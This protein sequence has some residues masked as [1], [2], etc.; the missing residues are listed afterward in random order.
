MCQLEQFLSH[1]SYCITEERDGPRHKSKGNHLSYPMPHPHPHPAPS[2]PKRRLPEL[3]ADGHLCSGLSG[4]ALTEERHLVKGQGPSRS[5]LH[6]VAVQHLPE[7]IWLPLSIRETAPS[8]EFPVMR[9]ENRTEITPQRG[10]SVHIGLHSLLS[11]RGH[12]EGRTL[13]LGSILKD[14]HSGL[15]PH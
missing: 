9:A 10:F 8:A 3:L 6:L 2:R 7:S 13:W 4:I 11:H 15:G 12:T 14:I 1:S 5:F